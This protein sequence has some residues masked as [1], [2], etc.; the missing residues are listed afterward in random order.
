M[1]SLMLL[2]M[3]MT[4]HT[5]QPAAHTTTILPFKL[6]MHSFD[7]HIE[8]EYQL[9]VCNR[10]KKLSQQYPNHHIVSFYKQLTTTSLNELIQEKTLLDQAHKLYTSI[11]T[12]PTVTS[13]F[14]QAVN[15]RSKHK[16]PSTWNQFRTTACMH[17]QK[18]KST[19]LPPLDL[20]SGNEPTKEQMN[21]YKTWLILYFA[22]KQNEYYEINRSYAQ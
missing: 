18:F 15:N 17:L 19:E 13:H 1:Y 8:Q 16:D 6:G 21:A 3:I 7:Q 2:L 14:T 5:T 11:Q 10:L 4:Y 12:C 20:S 9:H 22:I